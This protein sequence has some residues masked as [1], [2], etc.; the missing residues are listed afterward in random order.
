VIAS[1]GILGRDREL[2]AVASLVARATTGGG[3]LLIHGSAGIGKSVLLERVNK[4]L[5]AATTTTS[6]SAG[7]AS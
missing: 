4:T 5:Q 3:A 2:D 1:E 7:A 6:S